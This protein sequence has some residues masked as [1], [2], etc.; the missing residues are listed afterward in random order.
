MGGNANMILIGKSEKIRKNL[1]DLDADER[2]ILELILKKY[3]RSACI[4]FEW[5]RVGKS[6]GI[7]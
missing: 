7:F 2:V 3:D 6:E 4:V 5:L 1:E